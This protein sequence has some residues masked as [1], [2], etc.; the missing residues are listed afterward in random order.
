MNRKQ[1]R[2]AN[3]QP[4]GSI[5][6]GQRDQLLQ[7]GIN[8]LQ[9]GDANRAR[10]Y[11]EAVLK[12]N[13]KDADALHLDGVARYHGGDAKSA[14]L[15]IRKALSVHPHNPGYW[16]SL[17][18]V[19]EALGQTASTEK[20]YGEALKL[21]PE[22]AEAWNNYGTFLLPQGKYAQAEQ[23]YCKAVDLAPDYLQGRY[24]LAVFLLNSGRPAEALPH[25]E[26]GLKIE[27]DHPEFL[28]NYGVALQRVKRLDDARNAQERLLQVMPDNPGALTNLS[29]VYYDAGMLAEAEAHGRE[30]VRVSPELAPA[31]NNLANALAA[32]EKYNEAE[33]AQRR[34]LEI[35]PHFTE[36]VG[37]L[38][39][40][41][42]DTGRLEEAEALYL[43]AIEREPHNPRHRFQLGIAKM[44][45]GQLEEAWP[46]Y[47]A[48]FACGERVPDRTGSH[49]AP[50]WTGG[51]IQGGCL[52]IWPEQ[53]IGDEL[54]M[55]SLLDKLRATA[56]AGRIVYECDPRLV[57]LLQRSYPD[58]EVV[59]YG[60][61]DEASADFQIPLL[62]LM[63][64]YWRKPSDIEP[65]TG[66]V[67]PDEKLLAECRTRLAALGPA[68]TVGIAW[69]SGL[70]TARRAGALTRLRQWDDVLSVSGVNFVNL[71]Y[72]DC[73]DEI[74]EA[75]RAFGITIHRWP[76]IDLKDDLEMTLALT[77]SLDLVCNMGTSVGD[78]AAAA[79]TDCWTC[80][81]V[82]NWAMMGTDRLPTYANVEVIS[83]R[84]GTDWAE[85]LAHL[86]RKLETWRDG[87]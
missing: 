47:E 16:L 36:V 45:R 71:Q 4:Q 3:R 61:F 84:R 20:A 78:F 40:L 18:A 82:P 34:A 22:N 76:D 56:D 17:A 23:A 60:D 29:S 68:P 74:A 81:R 25:F 26:A 57:S 44:I 27:R 67:Q 13:P 87:R 1:R 31:W 49:P 83:R 69:S 9:A 66:F 19:E 41:M 64:I 63:G 52:H 24:N 28:I 58:V 70:K 72:G 55:A 75:E 33:A 50:R 46:L 38:A 35:A 80:L 86:A 30:A 11:F 14:R 62:S 37:N 65:R 7:Q 51:G 5:S 12:A 54:R 59:G 10:Q 42:E 53:G 85:T 39:N 32:Q 43:Q 8:L 2:Q 79:G 21:A 6:D 77:A 73:E 15:K 48:G